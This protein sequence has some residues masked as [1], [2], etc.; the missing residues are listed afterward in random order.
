VRVAILHNRYA[1]RGGE[2]SAVEAEAELLRKA[3]CEVALL[4]V[5]SAPLVRSRA[6]RLHA[7]L[8]AR[9]N[10]ETVERI[11]R[12]LAEHPADVAHVHNFFPLLSP[13]AHAALRAL[14]LP[15]VQTLHNYRLVCANGVFLREG[16]PCEECAVRGPWRAVRYGCLRGSRLATAVWAEATAA[17]R[18]RGTWRDCVDRFVAPSEFAKRKL[19][20]AGL[21][22]ERIVVKPNPVPDP[23]APAPPGRGAVYVGRL[24]SEKGVALL[25]DAWRS[26]PGAPPLAI[27][28]DGPEAP[29]LRARAHGIPGVRFLGEIPRER[30]PELLASA[31]FAVAPSLCY[32][33]FGLAVA[34]AMAA[35]RAVVAS[36]A[37][38]LAELVEPGATGLLFRSGDA[39]SLA[40]A[41]RR[42]LDDA[43]LTAAFGREAR[44]RFEDELAPER[45]TERLLR[46]Y[47]EVAA[48]RA[49]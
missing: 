17:H 2:D 47:A 22:A 19:A 3:G 26:L 36:D 5:E 9:W 35:G 14:G 13:S 30:V 41:C 28:G 39:A 27:A 38:A 11:A 15:V 33:T 21:P 8:R 29:R 6:A 34:E 23:G 48:A 4:T 16:R 7:A 12:F 31:A 20:A 46:L 42:L 18:R 45:S 24:S 44:A 25:V 32:E 43:G 37:G 49:R 40:D 10:P 1:Q